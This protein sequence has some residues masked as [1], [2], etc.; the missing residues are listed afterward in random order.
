MPRTRI[1]S[2]PTPRACEGLRVRLEARGACAGADAARLRGRGC[3]HQVAPGPGGSWGEPP[4]RGGADRASGGLGAPRS[5]PRAQGLWRSRRTR[6]A[7]R[8]VN[9]PGR[10]HAAR[11]RRGR[12]AAHALG[13]RR[14]PGGG[15]G[16]G[17]RDGPLHGETL[18]S[19][20]LGKT[21]GAESHA[22]GAGDAGARTGT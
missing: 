3:P 14:P 18:G 8:R 17:G 15:G 7:Q 16:N 6:P 5:R 13:A 12:A 1:G 22:S 9:K 21:G 2:Q 4:G 11:A 19:R 10:V 20:R